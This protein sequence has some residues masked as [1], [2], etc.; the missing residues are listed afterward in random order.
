MVGGG[1]KSKKIFTRFPRFHLEK[2]VLKYS[3]KEGQWV[4]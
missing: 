3:L 1:G 2:S 4:K